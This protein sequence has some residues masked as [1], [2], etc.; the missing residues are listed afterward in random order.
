MNRELVSAFY[1]ALILCLNLSF[2]EVAWADADAPVDSSKVDNGTAFLLLALTQD[3]A[4]EQEVLKSIKQNWQRNLT[5]FAIETL[6]FTGSQS[7]QLALL[8]LINAEYSKQSQ[9]EFSGDLDPIFQWWWNQKT[10]VASGYDNFKARLLSLIDPK[11]E[12]YFKHR[13]ELSLIRMDEI[14][15]GGVRQDGI[16][17]LRNPKLITADQAHYL[18]DDNIVFGIE[19]NGESTAYPKRI[20]AWHE[21]AVDQIGGVELAIVY[22]T[23]CGTVIPYRTNHN[24]QQFKLGTSGFLYRSNKLMYD[25][26]TQSLWSTSRGEPVVGPLISKG[27]RL[28]QESVVTTTWGAWRARHPKTKVLSL[29]TGHTRDY[30]EGVAYQNYFSTDQL[31]FSTPFNDDSLANKQEVLALRF[32]AAPDKQLAIDSEFLMRNTLY[33]N[34]IGQQQFVV[35]TDQSGANRV[36]E[37]NGKQFKRYDGESRLTDNNDTE[38]SLSESSLTSANGEELKRLPARRAFWFGWKAAFPQTKLIK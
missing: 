9:Q 23:L 17:P 6:L 37:S 19:L 2:T 3:R 15:W 29:D 20:L 38:W 11:F 7:K 34:Q 24:G 22:C 27:I 28:E 14:R 35:L 31:M 26:A 4:E 13:S 10:E 25:Q 36:Y 16:P 5:P 12:Q 30:G 1:A 33:T 8:E 21:M 32:P 18:A